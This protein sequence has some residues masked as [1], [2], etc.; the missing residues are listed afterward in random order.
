[1][2]RTIPSLLAA[3]AG[4]TV[5]AA[6][7]GASD[8]APSAAALEVRLSDAGCALTGTTAPAG[9]VTLDITNRG[10]DTFD[11]VYVLQGKKVEGEKEGVGKGKTG[12]LTLT[13]APGSYALHCPGDTR[14]DPF[15]VTSAT[16]AATS[17]ADDAVEQA[18]ATVAYAAYVNAQVAQQVAATK[19]LTNAVRRGD[20]AAAAAAYAGARVNYERIEPVAE[21]FGE[22]DA[23]VDARIGD[24]P[25]IAKWTGYHRLEYAV[26][27]QRSLAGLAV[28]A[29]GLDA[30]VHRLQTLV[31][32]ETY[33]ATDLANGA[34]ELLDEVARSKISGEEESYSHVDLVD[35]QANVDGARKAFELLEPALRK[36]DGALATTIGAAFDAVDNGLKPCRTGTGATDFTAY[37]SVPLAEQRTLAG[38]VDALAEPLSKVAAELVR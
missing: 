9:A 25:S 1:M 36:R 23:A 14:D 30:N 24:V 15:T 2:R 38:L 5:T 19:V 33:A 10:T 11:E 31:A 12:S 37:S 16:G 32:R 18:A 4:L 21:S 3:L 6:C 27:K 28:V 34:S 26:F 22:L 35:F 8:N 20:L 7:G 29:D 17:A 13:L